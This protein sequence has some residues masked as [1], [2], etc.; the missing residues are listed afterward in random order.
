MKRFSNRHLPR[1]VAG[2]SPLPLLDAAAVLL[3]V[4]LVVV[5]VPEGG[6]PGG[7]AAAEKKAPPVTAR[8][9]ISRDLEIT[10]DDA[11]VAASELEAKLRERVERTPAL[12]IVVHTPGSLASRSLAMIMETLHRAGVRHVALDFPDA[13]AAP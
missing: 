9:G 13:G 11:P 7:M 6:A 4:F 3:L 2:V 5:F 1:V 12:G 10:L 8:L